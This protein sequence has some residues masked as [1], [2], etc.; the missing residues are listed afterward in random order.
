MPAPVFSRNSL[1]SFADISAI[2]IFIP[3]LLFVVL[4]IST[5]L[6]QIGQKPE[7]IGKSNHYSGLLTL[8]SLKA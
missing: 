3:P 8:L 6:E 4:T 7:Q 2:L 1:T 5:I